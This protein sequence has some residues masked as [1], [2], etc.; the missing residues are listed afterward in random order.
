VARRRREMKSRHHDPH[1]DSTRLA[2]ILFALADPVR[3]RM[4]NLMLGGEVSS[5][6]IVRVLRVGADVVS[7][8]IISLQSGG[9]ISTRRR[10]RT[11]HYLIRR[12]AERNDVECQVIQLVLSSFRSQP[13]MRADLVLLNKISEQRPEPKAQKSRNIARS[14]RVVSAPAVDSTSSSYID[15]PTQAH[16][17]VILR[18]AEIPSAAHPKA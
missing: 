1:A 7:R 6:D 18:S 3:L 10:G 11:W 8:H 13:D 2:R 14:A 9:L 15:V 12:S 4:L 16:R 17:S 5:K